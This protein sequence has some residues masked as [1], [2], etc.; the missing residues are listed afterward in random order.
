MTWHDRDYNREP[1]RGPAGPGVSGFLYRLWAL[2]NW[3]FPLGAYFGIRVRVHITFL[4]LVGGEG[5]HAFSVGGTDWL[6]WTLRWAGLLFASVLLHEFGH[7][8]GC[9]AV[10]GRADDILMWPLG[11][12]AF[13]APPRRPWPEFVTVAC[14]PLVT[15][16]LTVAPFTVLSLAFPGFAH[17][18]LRVFNPF[19]MWTGPHGGAA[20]VLYDLMLVNY[21]LLLFN[22]CLAF[23]PFDGGRIVQTA[24]WAAVGYTTSMRWATAIGMAG[25]GAVGVYGL[26]NGQW[27]LIWLAVFGF[28]TCYR[29]SHGLIVDQ[30]QGA[31]EPASYDR[32]SQSTDRPAWL[33][34]W[35]RRRSERQ[36]AR[37]Q[38]EE[39]RLNSLVDRILAKVKERGLHSLTDAEKRA[40]QHATDRQRRAG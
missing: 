25:A 36:R 19:Q 40:L 1:P 3:S 13:C 29:Q 34:R 32:A 28:Y 14:G 6:L 33:A 7:C 11:G 21:S 26:L 37:R 5:L 22:L 23:Y 39:L 24:L 8:T 17:E 12:L 31:Y 18:Y 16:L 35:R 20:G 10:G 2:L 30:G 4:L 15:L 27:M 38:A 9:R